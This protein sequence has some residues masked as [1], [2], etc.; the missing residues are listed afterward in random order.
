[1]CVCVSIVFTIV[2]K[3][4]IHLLVPLQLTDDAYGDGEVY[5]NI[6]QESTRV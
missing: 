2:L 4:Y 1:M 5:A 3:Y 6:Y